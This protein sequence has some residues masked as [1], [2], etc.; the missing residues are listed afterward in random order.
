MLDHVTPL[1]CNVLKS[2]LTIQYHNYI[3]NSGY[4]LSM[5]NHSSVNYD[6]THI[7]SKR[8]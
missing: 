2:D 4:C 6:V 3:Q 5:N 1:L 8:L 7:I